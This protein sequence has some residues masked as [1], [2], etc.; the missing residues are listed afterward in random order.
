MSTDKLDLF[1]EGKLQVTLQRLCQQLIEHYGDFHDTVIIGLQPRGIFLAKRISDLLQT[2][3][4]ALEIPLGTLDVTFYRD[5]FRK[6]DIPISANQTK[7]DFLTENKQVILIDDVLY[8][9]RTVRAAM[10]AMLAYGRPSTV[11]LLV[12]VDRVRTRELP[13]SASYIGIK[14]ESVETERVL[15]ELKESGG[16]DKVFLV[17]TGN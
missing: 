1:P 6:R 9:G 3:I 2:R 12:L 17:S 15:V 14:V 5:D 11:S 7:I 8:T 16:G 10:D 4:P 13:V